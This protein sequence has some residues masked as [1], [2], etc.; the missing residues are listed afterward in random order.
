MQNNILSNLSHKDI[1]T[2][3]LSYLSINELKIVKSV[4]K[5]FLNINHTKVLWL[6]KISRL[7]SLKPIITNEAYE[8]Y[9]MYCYMKTFDVISALLLFKEYRVIELAYSLHIID[10]EGYI[11]RYN[12]EK[13]HWPDKRNQII[14][15][16]KDWLATVMVNNLFFYIK[17]NKVHIFNRSNDMLAK[18]FGSSNVDDFIIR[19][20]PY[21]GILNL[22]RKKQYINFKRP[23]A[24]YATRYSNLGLLDYLI[25]L[26]VHPTT[27]GISDSIR[28]GDFYS[29][30]RTLEICISQYG[31]KLTSILSTLINIAIKYN[32]F[33][34]LEWLLRHDEDLV[35]TSLK[36]FNTAIDRDYYKI[37]DI[38]LTQVIIKPNQYN[39]DN[40]YLRGNYK[41]VKWMINKHWFPTDDIKLQIEIWNHPEQ[42][43]KK[44]KLW[45]LLSSNNML[46]L[47]IE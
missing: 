10:L 34:I 39:I 24:D 15:R 29:A 4:C 36:S 1:N 22:I 25:T 44:R 43:N 9:K 40:A 42:S 6:I 21:P 38:L 35:N 12:N 2:Y 31:L 28:Y 3:I 32:K 13:L 18:S 14:V 23:H 27:N 8:L 17:D 46:L 37:L 45:K 20:S 19:K 30:K 47:I 26:G 33:Q 41:M 7:T 11:K 16:S 5:Y